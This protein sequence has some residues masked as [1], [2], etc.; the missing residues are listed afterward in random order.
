[1]QILFSAC[2]L[3]N[4]AS[5]AVAKELRFA[6]EHEESLPKQDEDLCINVECHTGQE[7]IAVNGIAS[8]VCK[9]SCPHHQNPV[10]GSNGMTYP[11]HCELH[12]TACLQGKKISIKNNGICKGQPTQPPPSAKVNHSK[13][14]VCYE[15]DRDEIRS[16]LIGWLKN[17]E[18]L[19]EGVEGYRNLLKSYFDLMDENNDGKLD[20]TEF[21]E[22]VQANQSAE[23]A[24]SIGEYINP[25][26]QS[27]CAD[28]LIAVSDEDSDWEL[29]LNEFMKCLD[30]QFKPPAKD[31][32][33]NGKAYHDGTEIPTDDCNS[34]VCACGHWVCTALKC[35]ASE[36]NQVLA[37]MNDE[38][39]AKHK[40]VVNGEEAKEQLIRA[41]VKQSRKK[42]VHHIQRKF[43]PLLK[44]QHHHKHRKHDRH[45]SRESHHREE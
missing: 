45:D 20:A 5:L 7:C 37:E 41:T 19:L 36:A 9:T 39:G 10:C 21:R 32:E 23:E 15:H 30:P 40:F 22:F 24:S 18:N 43:L 11:N 12:R 42:Q 14:V 16:R 28:A 1:M 25:I 3:W 4:L 17:Q 38:K 6:E 44:P 35:D 31:C 29:S 8:C 2:L 27:L 33:L 34:C 13:P 26:L